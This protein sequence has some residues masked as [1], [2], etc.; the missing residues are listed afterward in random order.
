MMT[1][2]ARPPPIARADD[3]TDQA[4]ATSLCVFR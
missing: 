3:E 2:V 1:A 4:V